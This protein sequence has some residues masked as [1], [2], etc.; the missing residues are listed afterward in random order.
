MK[1]VASRTLPPKPIVNSSDVKDTSN[2]KK[3]AIAERINKQVTLD[4]LLPE[5]KMVFKNWL[6]DEMRQVYPNKPSLWHVSKMYVL[7]TGQK[8]LIDEPVRVWEIEECEQKKKALKD[9]GYQYVM[10]TPKVSLL[11]ALTE[12]E[13]RL[14]VMA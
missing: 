4:G 12:S 7:K 8:L 6:V 3:L 14:D 10:V 5:N 13:V 11:E 9:L 1:K 2:S